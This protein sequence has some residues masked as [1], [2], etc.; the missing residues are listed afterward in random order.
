MINAD[1]LLEIHIFDIIKVN[2][3]GKFY[4]IPLANETTHDNII[5]CCKDKDIAIHMAKSVQCKNVYFDDS[6]LD[7][8]VSTVKNLTGDLQSTAN[9]YANNSNIS[10]LKSAVEEKTGVKLDD[11]QK[12]IE[13][14]TG[15]LPI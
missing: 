13:Q 6:Y 5:I 12:A 14:Y 15:K 2:Y 3:N 7:N 10:K 9:G 11:A 4:C 8:T 1:E